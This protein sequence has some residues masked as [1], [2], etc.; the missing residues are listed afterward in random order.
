MKNALVLYIEDADEATMI[1]DIIVQILESIK[2]SDIAT[3]A[4]E[5]IAC[6][7]AESPNAMLAANGVRTEIRKLTEVEYRYRQDDDDDVIRELPE[8]IPLH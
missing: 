8:P 3:G 7:Q 2:S 5:L 4:Y 6:N 1:R